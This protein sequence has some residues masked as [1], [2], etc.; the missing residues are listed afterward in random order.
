MLKRFSWTCHLVLGLALAVAPIGGWIAIT[1][2]FNW[3]I[4]LLGLAV[5]IWI[6]AFDVIY[7]CQDINFDK[8]QGL[9]SMPVRFGVTGAMKLSKIMHIISIASFLAVGLLL[10]LSYIYYCGVVLATLV[11]YYQHSIIKPDDLSEVT[12][13]YFMRN[14]LVGISIFLCTLIDLLVKF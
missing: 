8:A 4:I 2:Y 14:G 11:L 1:G 6:A 9:N 3:A 7:A 13:T 10:N 5:G 12:Q